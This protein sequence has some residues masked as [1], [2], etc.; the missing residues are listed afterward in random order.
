MPDLQF[1]SA[2]VVP[3]DADGERKLT[4]VM[5]TDA[6]VE[7]VDWERMEIIPEILVSRGGKFPASRQVPLLDNHRRDS[8]DDVLGSARAIRLGKDWEADLHFADDEKAQRTKGKVEGGHITDVS[9]GYHVHKRAYLAPG[10][11]GKVDGAEYEADERGLNVVTE[12]SCHEL[13]VT[14]VG[15]DAQAKIKGF[16][17][18][19]E[20]KRSLRASTQPTKNTDTMSTTATKPEPQTP[21]APSV[22]VE[23]VRKE[24]LEKGLSEG[25]KQEQARQNLIRQIATP[26]V[27]AKWKGVRELA[28]KALTDPDVTPEKLRAD[29]MT[30]MADDANRTI[31]LIGDHPQQF[32]AQEK[33]DLGSFRLTNL[34]R[35][36]LLPNDPAYKPLDGVERELDQEA[37]KEDWSKDAS[38]AALIPM[39][40]MQFEAHRSRYTGRPSRRDF[41]ATGTNDGEHTIEEDIV[42]LIDALKERLM[43]RQLGATVFGGLSGN[44]RFPVMTR[45]TA[46]TVKAETAAADD[47]SPTSS[48]ISMTPRRLPVVSTL[49]TQALIQS[50]I[51]VENYLRRWQAFEIASV[52]DLDCITT[53][54]AA[55]GAGSV[56]G[57]TLGWAEVVE[58]ETDVAT[59]NADFGR[60]AYL[61]D[62]QVRG[63]LKTT[64]KATNTAVF[65]WTDSDPQNG[66]LNGYRAAVTTQMPFTGAT[67]HAII[68]GNFADLFI[69]LWGGLSVYRDAVSVIEQ[70][71]I[72]IITETF[73]D[74]VVARG[75]SFSISDDVDLS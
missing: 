61:T 52:I 45:G 19:E 49:S 37:R 15:A 31:A 44:V 5:T 34:F 14:P 48:E 26:E 21:S 42:S 59:A 35:S 50:T 56:T 10:K 23:A 29:V 55:S 39:R 24:G 66:M 69:G 17:S 25:V 40:L 11:R 67:D 71:K 68:Y 41:L 46:P 72:R 13:S 57:S 6:P 54:I 4:A 43:V 62:P 16:Q 8:N 47:Y 73:F 9:I 2:K 12:W 1:R 58:F 65:L 74:T 75:E 28:D 20:A 18:W 32:S 63:H 60:L 30:I 64:E 70:G 3:V 38:G 36:L 53:I 27:C 33:K 7:T 22:D 51:D